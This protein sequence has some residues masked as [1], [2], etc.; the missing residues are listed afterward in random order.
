MRLSA[1]LASL[2][3]VAL[4]FAGCSGDGDGGGG[5]SSSSSSS[6]SS[7]SATSSPGSSSGTTTSA[8]SSTSTGSSANTPPAG[9][10]SAFVNGTAATFTLDGTD[11]DGDALSWELD[12]GDGSAK[13]T[14]ADL[15][16]NVT[17][18]YAVG[19]YTANFTID[20]GTDSVSYTV[21]VAAS[22]AAGAPQTVV[23]AGSI[24]APDPFALSGEG[25]I[26]PLADVAGS[27]TWGDVHGLPSE[28]GP[29]WT[30]LGSPDSVHATFISGDGGTIGGNGNSGTVG[31]GVSQVLVCATA[32][33]VD[34]TLTLTQ[35]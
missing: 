20:D 27:G 12:F 2:T 5:T 1:L 18:G 21:A 4:V 7:T 8:S 17:H 10:L 13:A 9:S 35:A 11:A 6:A 33:M 16:S 22:A 3:F 24:T 31:D 19:N 26:L 14:G 29:T 32:P 28:V 23:F 30:F 25:C 34:Y 15:P